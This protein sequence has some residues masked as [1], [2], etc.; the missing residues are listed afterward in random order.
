MRLSAGDFVKDKRT[1]ELLRFSKLKAGVDSLMAVCIKP[2]TANGA[3]FSRV[4]QVPLECLVKPKVPAGM[5]SV[6]E[7]QKRLQPMGCVT[8]EGADNRDRFPLPSQSKD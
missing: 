1:G 6:G 5:N 7:L 3:G 4:R 8:G 2:G